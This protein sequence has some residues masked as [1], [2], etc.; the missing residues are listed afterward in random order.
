M[1]EQRKL[2]EQTRSEIKQE[3]LKVADEIWANWEEAD[4]VLRDDENGYLAKTFVGE[5]NVPAVM[6]KYRCEGLTMEQW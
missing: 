4:E 5:D 3:L 1:A 6:T 2:Q